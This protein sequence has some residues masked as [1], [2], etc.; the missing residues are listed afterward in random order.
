[1]KV[2]SINDFDILGGH[3][4]FSTQASRTVTTLL[5]GTSF[6]DDNYG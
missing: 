6:F 3:C 1:M 5:N 2:S 4:D